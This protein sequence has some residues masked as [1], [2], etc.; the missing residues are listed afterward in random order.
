VLIYQPEK[1]DRIVLNDEFR[2]YRL[3]EAHFAQ[4]AVVVVDVLR[5]FTT[6][7][8]AINAGAEKIYPVSSV[9]EACDL[10]AQLEDAVIMGEVDGRKPENFDYSNSPAEIARLN[11]S[12]KSL[13][14]RTSAGTQG[15]V[16]A[17]NTE[18]LLVA[19]FVVALSTAKFMRQ[20]Q[21][22]QVS[23]VITGQSL[24]RDGDEDLA[25]A[26]YIGALIHEEKTDPEKFLSRVM[27]STVGKA[28][29]SG[30]LDYLSKEDIQLSLAVNR[31]NFCL[32]VT[33]ENGR[34]VINRYKF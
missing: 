3:D 17:R 5:A 8:Y 31:F 18:I 10:K 22:S 23:F 14:Q 2:F 34:L 16:K 9:E 7:A 20:M 26:A 13:I 24:G 27:S 12:G 19:S 21:P 25:C 6:A 4:G 32:P 30:D 11:L 33:E 15:I 28:F 1:K 29:Q